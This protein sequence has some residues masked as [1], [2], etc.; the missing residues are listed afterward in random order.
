VKIKNLGLQAAQRILSAAANTSS[1]LDPL[2][3]LQ[4]STQQ[5]LA[6]VLSL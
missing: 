4:A 5:Q 3:V 1:G 2:L 6:S